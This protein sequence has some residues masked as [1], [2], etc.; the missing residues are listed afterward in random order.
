MNEGSLI[1]CPSVLHSSNLPSAA[2]TRVPGFAVSHAGHLL[3][4]CSVPGLQGTAGTGEPRP[5]VAPNSEE[6]LA[7][8]AGPQLRGTCG[9]SRRPN[10]APKA[11]L[12]CASPAPAAPASAGDP[13]RSRRPPGRAGV[14]SPRALAILPPLRRGS[15][16]LRRPGA[17]SGPRAA[18]GPHRER[19]ESLKFCKQEPHMQD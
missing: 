5:G 6:T 13:P 1:P 3:P 7:R 9:S 17:A 19:E 15:R 4:A 14:A 8:A 10:P 16:H 11:R 18:A 12:A 2:P